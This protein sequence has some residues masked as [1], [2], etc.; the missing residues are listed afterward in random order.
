VVLPPLSIE[1]AASL[2]HSQGALNLKKCIKND[3]WVVFSPFCSKSYISIEE[4][5]ADRVIYAKLSGAS[6][7]GTLGKEGWG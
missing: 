4:I 5:F 3:T 1:W 7:Q 6:A 2:R